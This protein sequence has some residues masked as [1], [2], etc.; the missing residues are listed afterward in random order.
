MAVK[1]IAASSISLLLLAACATDMT[2]RESGALTGAALGGGGGAVLGAIAGSAGKG[3]LVGSAVGA[4]AG[5]MAGKAIEREQAASAYPL[6]WADTILPSPYTPTLQV[7]VTPE[8]TEIIIDGSLVGLA[9]ELYGPVRVSV[10]AGPHVVELSWRGFRITNTIVAP[11]WTTV[12]IKRDLQ[13]SASATPQSS[14]QADPQS[15]Y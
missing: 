2:P 14:P 8:D 12:L 6:W 7:D 11:P 5:L 3:A 4:V 1:R 10:T 13:P 15:P 9:R